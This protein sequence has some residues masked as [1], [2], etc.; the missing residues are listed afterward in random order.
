D[1]AACHGAGGGGDGPS[2][3]GMVPKPTS[4]RGGRIDLLSPFHVFNA[5]SFGVHG[6]AMPAYAGARTPQELWDIAFF[7]MTLRDGFEAR[8][9]VEVV[10]LPL[11]VLASESNEQVLRRLRSARPSAAAAEVDYYRANL[12]PAEASRDE[13]PASD[14]AIDEGGLRMA[15]TLERAFTR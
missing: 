6:T 3:A 8:P 5:A 12:P 10:P 7:V 2:A 13:G 1:C 9:P 14:V 15:E 4:F 11:A